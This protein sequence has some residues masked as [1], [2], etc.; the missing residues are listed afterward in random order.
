MPVHCES[1]AVR[2]E[3]HTRCTWGDACLSEQGSWDVTACCHE[4][5]APGEM[6][7]CP[8]NDLGMILQV[9]RTWRS[10]H[11]AVHVLE[12]ASHVEGIHK[13]VHRSPQAMRRLKASIAIHAPRTTHAADGPQHP[14]MP[15]S[16][17]KSKPSRICGQ[18]LPSSAKKSCSC[19]YPAVAP[20]FQAN[21]I[22]D[23]A[24]ATSC[25]PKDLKRPQRALPLREPA[26]AA[27]RPCP[28]KT[29]PARRA[30]A[31]GSSGATSG[32]TLLRSTSSVKD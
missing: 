22:S 15:S 6:G 24:A 32:T 21:V 14:G 20:R 13:A 7:S 1:R 11:A 4:V 19:L 9:S 29:Q 23:Q 17:D 28:L 2:Q 5:S 3:V 30:S 27:P 26:K 10:N 16:N 8:N 18:T 31:A 25:L 12:S